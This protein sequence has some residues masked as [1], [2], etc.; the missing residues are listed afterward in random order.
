V[1]QRLIV[2]LG[3]AIASVAI[4][5]LATYKEFAKISEILMQLAGLIASLL[6][7]WQF[8]SEKK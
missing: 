8:F 6:A 3:I 2:F 5:L 1:N 7:I 4:L